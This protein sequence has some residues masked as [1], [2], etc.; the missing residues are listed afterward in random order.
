MWVYIDKW[1][2]SLP[3]EPLSSR[4]VL[5]TAYLVTPRLDNDSSTT[6]WCVTNSVI[7]IVCHKIGCVGQNCAMC[8]NNARVACGITTAVESHTIIWFI[9]SVLKWGRALEPTIYHFDFILTSVSDFLLIPI[10]YVTKLFILCLVENL[11]RFLQAPPSARQ[12]PFRW[13]LYAQERILFVL[14]YVARCKPNPI[15]N[16]ILFLK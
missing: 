15:S 12:N 11:L 16:N 5:S 8:Y 13:V 4:G 14:Y 9:L 7:A 6:L 10:P 2:S 1:Y 3:L